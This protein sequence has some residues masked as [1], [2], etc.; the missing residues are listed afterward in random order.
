[1]RFKRKI[2]EE[3]VLIYCFSC[4]MIKY[5]INIFDLGDN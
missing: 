2:S 1:M 3:E 4:K 5:M